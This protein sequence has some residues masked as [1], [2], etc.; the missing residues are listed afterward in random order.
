[1]RKPLTQ[2]ALSLILSV[3]LECGQ[4]T[5]TRTPKPGIVYLDQFMPTGVY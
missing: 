3:N 4:N 1:M 5:I 2:I